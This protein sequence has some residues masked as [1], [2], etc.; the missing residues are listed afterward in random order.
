MVAK[1]S[2]FATK[3]FECLLCLGWPEFE[4]NVFI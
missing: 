4:A 3:L 1:F 2:K